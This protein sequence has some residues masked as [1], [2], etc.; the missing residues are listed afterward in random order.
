MRD[1][2]DEPWLSLCEKNFSVQLQNHP[3]ELSPAELCVCTR[4]GESWPRR[5][6]SQSHPL[7]HPTPCSCSQCVGPCK[8]SKGRKTPCR[9]FP[10]VHTLRWLSGV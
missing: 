5:G 4:V 2:F 9:P 8:W 6:S 10:D 1:P 7:H 3:E